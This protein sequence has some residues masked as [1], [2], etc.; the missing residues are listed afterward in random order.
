MAIRLQ[1]TVSE[2]TDVPAEMVFPQPIRIQVNQVALIE[3]YHALWDEVHTKQDATPEWFESWCNRVPAFSCNCRRD[4]QRYIAD[5]P[6]DYA[7]FHNWGTRLHNWVNKKLGKPLWT[8]PDA[9]I[10]LDQDQGF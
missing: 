3:T 10:R 7:N 1:C 8:E 6:V 9:S 2:Y 4:L 5:N